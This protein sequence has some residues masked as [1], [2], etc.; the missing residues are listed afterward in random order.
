MSA[1]TS[2]PVFAAADAIAKRFVQARLEA[3]A[4]AE[5]P[6]P[7]P[8]DRASAYTCQDAAIALWPDVIAG[9]KV[10]RPAPGQKEGFG[11]ARL[12]GPIFRRAVRPADGVVQAPFIEGG[13]AA[14]E[15]EFVYRI[16]RDA[17]ADKTSW[18]KAEAEALVE[19][20]HI[21]VE[22]AGSPLA[23]INALGPTVTVADFGNNAGLILGPAVADW[24]ERGLEDLVC[25]VFINGQSVG[26]ANATALPGGPMGSLRFLLGH[27]AEQGRPL[28]AGQ[29]V[30]TGAVTGVHEIEIGQ[31]A[32]ADFGALG[33]IECEAVRA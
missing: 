25:E 23:L 6:G 15:G 29:L 11:Q 17:P 24:R 20:M 22:T 7:V 14:I 10:G 31:S 21:G 32:H 3:R 16:G 12:A 9:W 13:F 28:K 5:F 8:P 26:R 18:S 27:C 2:A 33:V 19:A 4:L 30:S 1:I